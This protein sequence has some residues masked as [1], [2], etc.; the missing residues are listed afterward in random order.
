MPRHTSFRERRASLWREWLDAKEAPVAWTARRSSTRRPGEPAG[1]FHDGATRLPRARLRTH[2]DRPRKLLIAAAVLARAPP[3]PPAL[4]WCLQARRA[5]VRSCVSHA[6]GM[7][8]T[9]S[10]FRRGAGLPASPCA[11]AHRALERERRHRRSS[12]TGSRS[13]SRRGR[14]SRAAHVTALTLEDA[15]LRRDARAAPTP[16]S[17]ATAETGDDAR[18][19]ACDPAV[20]V[21]RVRQRGRPALVRDCSR[22]RAE[23]SCAPSGTRRDRRR[24]ARDRRQQAFDLARRRD[25]PAALGTLHG[26]DDAF[27]ALANPGDSAHRARRVPH[28]PEPAVAR[29]GLPSSSTASCRDRC[30]ARTAR[31]GRRAC[32]RDAERRCRAGAASP[33]A[34]RASSRRSP[35]TATARRVIPACPRLCV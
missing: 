15:T 2:E 21:A 1:L 28:P 12:P 13:R 23:A 24:G 17:P 34:A 16:T 18:D 14:C 26:E 27:R 3:P 31:R 11:W 8:V 5:R 33:S 9:W 20:A 4:S 29:R 10:T 35:R 30:K 19:S 7:D 32:A 22:P 6:R 25:D